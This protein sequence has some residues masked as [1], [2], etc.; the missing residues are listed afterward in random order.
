[1]ERITDFNKAWDRVSEGYGRHGVTARFALKGEHGAVAFVLYTHWF[2]K[3]THDIIL[4]EAKDLMSKPMA[5][6]IGY[7]SLVP[8]YEGQSIMDHNCEYCNGKDC[9]YDGSSLQAE[10]YFETLIN[11]GSEGLWK[12]MESFYISTFGELT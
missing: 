6:D 3:K 5:A 2:P 9:Y 12:K 8:M 11:E 1:M 7:H 10:A 4:N